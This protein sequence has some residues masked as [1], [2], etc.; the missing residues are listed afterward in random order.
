M[1]F[2]T[3][4][5]IE[6]LTSTP[7]TLKAMLSGLSETRIKATEG[8]ATWSAYDVVG[9]LIH[10]EETD[11]IP[12]LRIILESGESVPFTP[13]D[14]DAQFVKSRGKLLGE[15]L[16]EFEGLRK[17]NI[18]TLTQL[19][20]NGIDLNR[21]GMHPELGSVT[22]HQLLATWVVHDLDHLYQI[23][24]TLAYGYSEDVGPWRL[25]V[26]DDGRRIRALQSQAR[27]VA[28]RGERGSS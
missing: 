19:L 1:E 15:L 8:G 18:A 10:G 12:R 25:R 5:V 7:I 27:S 14:R 17:T 26:L 9:H 13:F 22:I 11:W 2:D 21:R 3:R 23:A 16:E 24:R 4:D 28:Q 6:I 20:A